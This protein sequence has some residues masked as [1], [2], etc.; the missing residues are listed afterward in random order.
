MGPERFI[1]FLLTLWGSPVLADDRPGWFSKD[2]KSSEEWGFYCESQGSNES[3]ALQGA[4]AQCSSKICL[5]FGVEVDYQVVTKEDLKSASVSAT[6][7]EKCPNV[8]VSGRTE[9][10]KS[11]ECTDKQCVAYI[12]QHYPKAEYDKEYRRLN[13]PKISQVIEKTI[14]VREGT[15]TFADPKPCIES[16][17]DYSKV[18][19]EREE[20]LKR[21]VSF[22][23]RAQSTCVNLDYRD[24]PLANKINGL[25]IS[26]F[27]SR[28]AS[29]AVRLNQV[30]VKAPTYEAKI[31]QLLQFEKDAIDGAPRIAQL[32]KF[33][34]DHYDALFG[35]RGPV[36]D[37]L[38]ELN[39][40]RIHGQMLL[41][42][43]KNFTS[44]V[45]P[46]RKRDGSM[47]NVCFSMELSIARGKY[48]GCVCHRGA[49]ENPQ[50]CVKSLWT[51][52][53]ES[54]PDQ[55]TPE[56]MKNFSQRVAEKMK[57]DIRH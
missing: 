28:S 30:L 15:T 18:R 52:L 17:S 4:R 10:K 3:E 29:T 1:I 11:V 9:K 23:T 7:I 44:S 19:G 53:E 38:K 37:Y 26:A 46:C 49:K 50:E 16:V 54:C 22:L 21:R 56:C 13:Q 47:E 39:S 42:W 5:L 20:D 34:E 45:V 43:P 57:M 32:K 41:L 55:F 24:I 31:A 48:L 2:F 35:N 14:V 27:G 51:F 33:M 12:L 6:T 40:C 36:E 25:M 8:R